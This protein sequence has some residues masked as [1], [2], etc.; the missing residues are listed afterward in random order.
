MLEERARKFQ[1]E[2]AKKKGQKTQTVA[3]S[4]KFVQRPPKF[5]DKPFV[6]EG[7][8][9]APLDKAT[10]LM[11]RLAAQSQGDAGEEEEDEE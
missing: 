7:A 2:L 9:T 5:L 11:K 6:N 8:Q 1:T 4:P 10:A 3:A